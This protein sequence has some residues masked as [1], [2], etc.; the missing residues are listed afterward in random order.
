MHKYHRRHERLLHAIRRDVVFI[1]VGICSYFIVATV[2]TRADD[3]EIRKGPGII[4]RYFSLKYNYS[5]SYAVC[6]DQAAFGSKK[7]DIEQH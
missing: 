6:D 2:E 7:N 5:E 1:F 4:A 3:V